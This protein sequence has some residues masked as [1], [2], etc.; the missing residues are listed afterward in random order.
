MS[1][2]A[3]ITRRA[4]SNLTFAFTCVPKDRREDLNTFYAFCRV[5]DDIADDTEIPLEKK[6]AGLDAWKAALDRDDNPAGSLEAAV[7]AMR[8]RRQVN[9]EHL[10]EIILGCESD[11]TPQRFGT[12]DDLEKYNYQVASAVGLVLVPLLGASEAALSYSRALGQCL[13][14]TNIIRDVGEDLSNGVRIYLPLADLHRFQYT[15]RDLIGR[16]YD[17]RFLAL[18]RFEADR[19]EG[20]FQQ[21]MDLLPP[22]DRK[23]LRATE[24]MR[25]IYHTL[26]ERMRDDNFRVFDR[27]YS[28][29]KLRK[30]SI[31]LR[32]MIC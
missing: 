8:E 28:I 31:L 21:T 22:G 11:I 25:E 16:V 15:E 20:L 3:D 1:E 29:S 14:L 24:I 19:A 2:A 26:L 6:K 4:K 27:R 17:G 12:W 7:V 18:M 9:P 5:V 32:N 13:Q 30:I 23:K 10:H